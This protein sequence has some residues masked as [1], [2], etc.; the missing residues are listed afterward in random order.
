MI[1]YTARSKS[2]RLREINSGVLFRPSSFL[3]H[4]IFQF[5]LAAFER[6]RR[7]IFRIQGDTLDLLISPDLIFSR[8]SSS[9]GEGFGISDL[10]VVARNLSL[11]TGDSIWNESKKVA[12]AGGSRGDR[13]LPIKSFQ[14]PR[15]FFS[16]PTLTWANCSPTRAE[17]PATFLFNRRRPEFL[18]VRLYSHSILVTSIIF[19]DVAMEI[20]RGED[21][22]VS[23]RGGDSP[24]RERKGHRSFR[25]TSCRSRRVLLSLKKARLY[26]ILTWSVSEDVSQRPSWESATR[27]HLDGLDRK[28]LNMTIGVCLTDRWERNKRGQPVPNFLSFEHFS[29]FLYVF[30]LVIDRLLSA[31]L[32]R[33]FLVP[34]AVENKY[35]YWMSALTSSIQFIEHIYM[36]TEKNKW[37]E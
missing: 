13:P 6:A 24:C 10:I 17:R 22:G 5:Y 33:N 34:S 31:W 1:R 25:R 28:R 9:R 30:I 21:L 11:R 27:S 18:A 7:V 23:S 12:V 36:I 8:R 29:L 35:C 16:C 4:L 37:V 19:P 14:E 3:V 20:Q 32:I 2:C 26:D 15:T